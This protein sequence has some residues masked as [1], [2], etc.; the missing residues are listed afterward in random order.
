MS[1]SLQQFAHILRSH[2]IVIF[3]IVRMVGGKYLKQIV[4]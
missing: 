3:T 4:S 1:G 2:H